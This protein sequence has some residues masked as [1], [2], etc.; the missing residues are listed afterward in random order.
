METKKRIKYHNIYLILITIYFIYDLI[1][2][3]YIYNYNNIDITVYFILYTIYIVLYV[4]YN[5][6]KEK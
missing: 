2:K 5:N 3:I 4:H 1:S 6:K